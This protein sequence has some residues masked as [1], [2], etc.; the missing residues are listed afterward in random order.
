MWMQIQYLHLYPT[1]AGICL[2]FKLFVSMTLIWLDFKSTYSNA[3][4]STLAPALP[5]CLL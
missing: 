5:V 1:V 2:I 4:Y 3:F